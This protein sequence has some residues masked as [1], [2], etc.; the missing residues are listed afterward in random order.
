MDS[1]EK[2][3]GAAGHSDG[4][5]DNASTCTPSSSLSGGRERQ[6]FHVALETPTWDWLGRREGPFRWGEQSSRLLFTTLVLII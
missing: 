3:P 2:V 4:P 1:S 6:T 5:H